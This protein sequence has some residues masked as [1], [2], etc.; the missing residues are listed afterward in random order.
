MKSQTDREVRERLVARGAEALTDA[1]L[2]SLILPPKRGE[3]SIAVAERL[4]ESVGSIAAIAH[5]S[6]GELRQ[7]ESLGAERAARVVA[8]MELGRRA[9]VAE[10][11][12]VTTI[13]D[14]NDIVKLFGPLLG[15]LNHEEMW[16]L[17]L[18]SSNRIIERR[19][20]SIGGLSS[21]TTDCRLIIR[22][23]LSLVAASIIVVHNHPS[24]V[25]SPSHEDEEF[26][27][28]LR[29]AAELFDI[30]LLDHII[31]A[32]DSS[33]SFRAHSPILSAPKR[34]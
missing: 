16:V 27:R 30:A 25:A 21:L 23:A 13:R 20:I 2:L 17:Y 3:E 34:R 33:Y 26:T 12:E 14:Y 7:M 18:S 8:A 1:E 6:L 24:G 22:H 28:R 4:I 31:V 29:E 5:S 19:R 10:G 32:R 9:L 15:G 11:A